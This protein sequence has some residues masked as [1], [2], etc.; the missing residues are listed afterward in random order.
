MATKKAANKV[1]PK[2]ATKAA[3]AS[4]KQTKDVKTVWTPRPGTIAK[5]VAILEKL[6]KKNKGILPTFTEINAAGAFRSY[7]VARMNPAPFKHL[8]DNRQYAR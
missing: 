7:E 6:A 4:K 1:A 5:H 2:K 3:K 8:M